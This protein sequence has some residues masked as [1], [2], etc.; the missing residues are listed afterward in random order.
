MSTIKNFKDLLVWQKAHTLV[1]ETYKITGQFPNLEKFGLT[2][3]M[4]RA[5]LSITS[6][7]AEGF[8]RNTDKDK[9]H[10]LVMARGSSNELLSQYLVAYDLNFINSNDLA[11]LEQ[12]NVEIQKMLSGLIKKLSTND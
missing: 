7:I 11:I 9:V 5:A 6:N 2:S 1:I 8:G 4:R 3:Q 12:K 10:F